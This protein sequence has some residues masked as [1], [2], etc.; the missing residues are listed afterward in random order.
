MLANLFIMCWLKLE[1]DYNLILMIFNKQEK[2]E[3]KKLS[4]IL[5]LKLGI[6]SI[7]K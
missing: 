1:T 7:N 4:L 2:A 6:K 5:S 3:V